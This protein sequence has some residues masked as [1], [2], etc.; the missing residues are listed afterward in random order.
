[1]V[2][3]G[4]LEMQCACA[5]ME[6]VLSLLYDISDVFGSSKIDASLELVLCCWIRLLGDGLSGSRCCAIRPLCF[7]IM[8]LLAV[9][10]HLMDTSKIFKKYTAKGAIYEHWMHDVYVVNKVEKSFWDPV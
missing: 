6:I 5:S 3:A 7:M 4:P 2:N 9:I 1:M 10:N 8:H